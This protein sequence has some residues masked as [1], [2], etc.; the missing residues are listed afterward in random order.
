[1]EEFSF[2]GKGREGKGRENKESRGRSGGKLE[3]VRRRVDK[4]RSGFT[5]SS[6]KSHPLG[7]WPTK[8][9]QLSPHP[10]AAISRTRRWKLGLIRRLW[11]TG[12][13]VFQPVNRSPFRSPRPTID[14][15]LSIPDYR[16]STID[17]RLSIV[18]GNRDKSGH[19]CWRSM[20]RVRSARSPRRLLLKFS[21]QL[22]DTGLVN[23]P[24]RLLRN[25]VIDGVEYCTRTD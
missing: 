19:T 13:A 4:F 7:G 20:A 21:C 1:M 17:G 24:P 18:D 10:R 16:C 14:T 3:R 25:R 23:N 6:A 9:R 12:S 22:P 15:R 5:N 11:K 2:G 8:S